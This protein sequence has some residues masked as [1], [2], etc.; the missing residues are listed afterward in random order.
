MKL[1]LEQLGER[2]MPYVAYVGVVNHVA[3]QS[4][5]TNASDVPILVNITQAANG[6]VGIQLQGEGSTLPDWYYHFTG[7][8]LDIT[9]PQ[10]VTVQVD[11][12]VH[13]PVVVSGEATVLHGTYPPAVVDMTDRIILNGT[14]G[15]PFTTNVPDAGD[16]HTHGKDKKH[17]P[18]PL[19]VPE[20]VTPVA[21]VDP[22]AAGAPSVAAPHRHGSR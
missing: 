16:G 5:D 1:N 18:L 7:I 10:P 11:N 21:P 14:V 15:V 12:S 4:L 17:K 3:M 22:V 6:D 20:H 8:E 9:G 2:T 19:A 13:V